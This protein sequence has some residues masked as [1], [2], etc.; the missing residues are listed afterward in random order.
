[1]HGP[2]WRIK[3][4]TEIEQ[5]NEELDTSLPDDDVDTIGGLVAK[6]LARSTS[7]RMPW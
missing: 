2:R 3:A 5:F 6:H 7:K 1:M 4:L